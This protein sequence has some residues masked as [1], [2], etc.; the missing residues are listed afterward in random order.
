MYNK[1]NTKEFDKNYN[2]HQI[3][4]LSA[5]FL[6]NEFFLQRSTNPNDRTRQFLFNPRF[7]ISWDDI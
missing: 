3:L 2:D 1:I 4:G 5:H 6:S 7:L